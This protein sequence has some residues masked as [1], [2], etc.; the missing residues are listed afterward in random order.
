[1]NRLFQPVLRKG[2][3]FLKGGASTS[4]PVSGYGLKGPYPDWTAAAA[5]CV[6]YHSSDILEAVEAAM[7]EVASGKA[8]MER[9]GVALTNPQYP[10]PLIAALLDQGVRDAGQLGVL[11]FGGSLG[12]SYHASR[13]WLKGL[14]RIRWGVVEQHTFFERG[15]ARWAGEELS[16]FESIE[17][18]AADLRPNVALLSGV[19]MYLEE[20]FAILHQLMA[21]GVETIVIDR[22][23][24]SLDTFPL[25]FVEEVTMPT[26]TA[27]YPC[28]ALTVPSIFSVLEERYTLRSEFPTVD[29]APPGHANLG[30]VGAI[31]HKNS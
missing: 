11:D 22:T 5:A 3:R 4:G 30:F 21:T 17:A 23:L 14:S 20:P 13:N 19:L 2:L 26:Y 28:R 12:S 6:G 25:V 15:R 8:A 29:A 1:M 31:F 27:S 16:F 10:F 9:D 24:V 7:A 18:C